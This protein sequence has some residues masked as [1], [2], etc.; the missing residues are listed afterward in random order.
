[1]MEDITVKHIRKVLLY[2]T[3]SFIL[4]L[5][6][7]E[8]APIKV[9]DQS[10]VEPAPIAA[11][12]DLVPEI[13][14]QRPASESGSVAK[15]V[16]SA[17]TAVSRGNYVAASIALKE[18]AV[19]GDPTAQTA[20]ATMYIASSGG[21]ILDT[22]KALYWFRKAA[23]QGFPEAQYLLGEMYNLGRGVIE[24]DALAVEWY[25]KA[26]DQG[27]AHAQNNMGTKYLNGHGVSKDY[28]IARTWYS[29]SAYQGNIFGQYNLAAM[30]AGGYGAPKDYVRGYVWSKLAVDQI[31]ADE[32]KIGDNAIAVRDNALRKMSDGQWEEARKMIEQVSANIK[33]SSAMQSHDYV[34]RLKPFTYTDSISVPHERL[35][36][37]GFTVMPPDDWQSARMEVVDD[38][39]VDTTEFT[40]AGLKKQGPCKHCFGEAFASLLNLDDQRFSSSRQ[41]LEF[42]RR[43]EPGAVLFSHD[44]MEDYRFHLN[45][46]EDDSEDKVCV[47]FELTNKPPFSLTK[48]YI[49]FFGRGFVCI[50]PLDP[51]LALVAIRFSSKPNKLDSDEKEDFIKQAERFLEDIEFTPPK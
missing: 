9:E 48:T 30:Y 2:L 44:T 8:T 4:A 21:V 14:L 35:H 15:A 16:D 11:V 17:M 25:R 1:M 27:H 51:S 18:A 34:D 38:N 40:I 32:P 47:R 20:L 23:E 37:N 7:C 31:S 33:R 22:K 12:E 42:M 26:A 5:W 13:K 46:R 29:K 3:A 28:A 6:G 41:L 10:V 50:H 39:D 36:F 49:R 24:R 43:S 45:Y 19:H